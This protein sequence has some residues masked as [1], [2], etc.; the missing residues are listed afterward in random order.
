MNTPLTPLE[1]WSLYKFDAESKPK[2]QRRRKR[3]EQSV[4]TER[5][6]NGLQYLPNSRGVFDESPAHQRAMIGAS[7]MSLFRDLSFLLESEKRRLTP[8]QQYIVAKHP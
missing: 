1:V 5:H 2:R 4:K 6:P 3:K 7:P 8:L